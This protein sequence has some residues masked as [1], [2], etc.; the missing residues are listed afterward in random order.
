MINT[1]EHLLEC[2]RYL[3]SLRFVVSNPP[4]SP[5]S[6][7]STTMSSME[8]VLDKVIFFHDKCESPHRANRRNR[9]SRYNQQTLSDSMG[10]PVHGVGVYSAVSMEDVTDI[11]GRLSLDRSEEIRLSLLATN[12]IVTKTWSPSP[13]GGL[14]SPMANTFMSTPLPGSSKEGSVPSTI[15]TVRPSPWKVSIETQQ[16]QQ[17]LIQRRLLQNTVQHSAEKQKKVDSLPPSPASIKK[18]LFDEKIPQFDSPERRVPT[19]IGHDDGNLPTERLKSEKSQGSDLKKDGNSPKS[20]Y[21]L[22]LGIP[23]EGCGEDLQKYY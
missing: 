6:T 2:L 16:Y 1:R 19:T 15:S 13:G 22:N 11:R 20:C 18:V 12:P 9:D 4:S 17:S 21:P 8:E 23:P 14:V 3:R 5:T 7:L 10:T